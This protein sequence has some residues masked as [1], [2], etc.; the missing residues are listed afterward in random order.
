MNN[1]LFTI[2]GII[3]ILHIIYSVRKGRLSIVESFFWIIGGIAILI[4]SIFPLI[5]DKLS[6]LVGI[7][8][9]PSL[10]FLLCTLFL[11]FMNFRASQNQAVQQEKIIELAQRIALLENEEK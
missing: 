3:A 6:E 1:I 8:Y 9:P 11:I 4:L 7:D 2:L 5:L 10:L